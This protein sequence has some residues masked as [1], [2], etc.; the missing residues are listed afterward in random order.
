MIGQILAMIE[1][2]VTI[3]GSV[4]LTAGPYRLRW[5]HRVAKILC[6]IMIGCVM[7]IGIVN[8]F[9]AK[10]SS[11]EYTIREIMLLFIV[12][13]FFKVKFWQ[14]CL[15]NFTYWGSLK[16]IQIIAVYIIRLNEG[17]SIRDYLDSSNEIAWHWAHLLLMAG[18]MALVVLLVLFKKG[19]EFIVC[20]YRLSYI[21]LS[22]IIFA[23]PLVEPVTSEDVVAEE[24]TLGPVVAMLFMAS[25]T[26]CTAVVL[27]VIKSWFHM[28]E[29]A[30]VSDQNFKLLQVQ[31]QSMLNRYAQKRRQIH[32]SIQ[33]DILL[34]GY[35]E[36]GMTQQAL[37]CLQKNL[38]EKRS[39]TQH[40]YTG[41]PA[42]DCILNYKVELFEKYD[43]HFRLD[44]DA[45][46]CPVADSEI[47]I[48]LGNLL[49]NAVEAVWDLEKEKRWISLSLKTVNHMFLL[50]MINP[51]EGELKKSGDHYET[52]KA[53]K[54]NHGFGLESVKRIAEAY[55]C[56][57]E[58]SDQDRLFHVKL[59]LFETY[60]NK[61][62]KHENTVKC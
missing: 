62:K 59:T 44:S 30:L 6:S 34:Q 27:I 32:D 2:V 8:T 9:F 41:L 4:I 57:A 19:E 20:K 22:M 49:D 11:I 24:M 50:D 14:Q 42:L 40:K 45:V 58:I 51:Y 31:Y 25:F 48:I 60:Q 26:F 46:F 16:V 36:K 39:R 23:A 38:R 15:Q 7:I 33:R 54:E 37:D 55:N 12:V 21:L 35:L 10:F 13:L 29:R 1:A 47:C 17:M 28:R 5:N 56:L 53:D 43:I 61:D 3:M 52:T 18:I